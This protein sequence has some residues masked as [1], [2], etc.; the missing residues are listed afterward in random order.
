MLFFLPISCF[1]SL[2][3]QDVP[4]PSLSRSNI[5]SDAQ[6]QNTSASDWPYVT[7][8]VEARYVFNLMQLLVATW[9]TSWARKLSVHVTLPPSLA[10][11]SSIIIIFYTKKIKTTSVQV[12]YLQQ[13][14]NVHANRIILLPNLFTQ[15]TIEVDWNHISMV[16]FAVLHS[17]PNVVTIAHLCF[18]SFSH[19]I[20]IPLEIP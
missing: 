20:P 7:W 13:I 18:P 19:F 12:I 1:P 2:S 17:F 11:A 4:S 15:V 3:H 14:Q 16:P 5:R 10:S 9:A 8:V 6:S